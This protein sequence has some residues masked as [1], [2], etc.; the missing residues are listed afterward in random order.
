MNK[1]KPNQ[2]A[3]TAATNSTPA[4]RPGAQP[5]PAPKGHVPAGQG[6]QKP[7]TVKKTG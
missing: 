6:W 4:A 5:Q 7:N 2:N 1:Y 3:P